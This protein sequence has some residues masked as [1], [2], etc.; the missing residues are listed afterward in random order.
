M[1]TKEALVTMMDRSDRNGNELS[2]S[3]GKHRNFVASSL[4]R[5]P[6]NP[7]I[8]TLAAIAK[9]CGYAIV[10]EGHGDRIEIEA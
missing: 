10:L 1:T 5:N 7:T 2:L 3:L 9:A 8:E 6:W 4:R